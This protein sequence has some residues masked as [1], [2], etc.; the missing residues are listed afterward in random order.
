MPKVTNMDFLNAITWVSW[1]TI[2]TMNMPCANCGTSEKVHQHHIRHIR[3]RA[4][5]LIPEANSYQKIM[6]LRNRKQIALCENCH[7]S[8]VHGGKYDGPKLLKLS[9]Q[10][11]L[12]DNRIIHIES[13]IKPGVPYY[14]KSLIEKGWKKITSQRNN[15]FEFEEEI[16]NEDI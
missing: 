16:I 14:S 6:S 10:K 13:F 9:P 7:L 4:Y 11:K 5:S 2:A 12:I 1:R 15:N 8:L 3:K